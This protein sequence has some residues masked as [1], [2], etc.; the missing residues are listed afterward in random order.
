MIMM[1][2]MEKADCIILVRE[3]TKK[4]LAA[5]RSEHEHELL[6]NKSRR[7]VSWDDVIGYLLEVKK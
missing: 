1:I 2:M 6:K 7:Y 3:K 5:F 4:K